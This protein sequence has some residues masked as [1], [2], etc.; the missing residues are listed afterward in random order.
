MLS[1]SPQP[2]RLLLAHL[3]LPSPI[4]PPPDSA[5]TFRATRGCGLDGIFSPLTAQQWVSW[6]TDGP[7]PGRISEH[8]PHPTS[9]RPRRIH[10]TCV[11]RDTAI[12]NRSHPQLISYLRCGRRA[13]F[14]PGVCETPLFLIHS[15]TCVFQSSHRSVLTTT[16][17]ARRYRQQHGWFSN[18]SHSLV[19]GQTA[20]TL[21]P[22]T[23]NVNVYCVSPGTLT[24]RHYLRTL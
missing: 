8:T 17:C 22:I 11:S 24:P 19:D 18:D 21:P 16:G 6:W 15:T 7:T 3:C 9:V 12:F 20:R 23:T 14:V 4:T 5:F 1:G 13:L 2:T 10:T